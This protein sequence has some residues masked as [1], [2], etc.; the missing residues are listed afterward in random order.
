MTDNGLLLTISKL[1][2]QKLEME[3]QPILDGIAEL[4]ENIRNLESEMT[5]LKTD[6]SDLNTST[7]HLKTDITDFRTDV[8]ELK[9]QVTEVRLRNITSDLIY[10]DRSD[11]KSK[12]HTELVCPLDPEVLEQNKTVLHYIQVSGLKFRLEELGNKLASIQKK[13]S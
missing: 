12:P 2:D 9:R 4:K 5:T 13:L 11:L 8:A 6:L 1:M 3:S 10:E 7:E